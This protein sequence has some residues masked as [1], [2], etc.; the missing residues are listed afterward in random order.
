MSEVV[1]N[2]AGSNVGSALQAL[3][4]CDELVPGSDVSYELCKLIYL[5]HP[6]GAKIAEGPIAI[7]QSQRREIL[8]QDSGIQE[9]LVERFNKVWDE[10]HVDS[11]IFNAYR[12][13]RIYGV[14]T[15]V[16]GAVGVPTDQV[17]DL[18]KLKGLE[19]YFNVLDPLN[20]AGSMVFNQD[21]NSPDFQ[22]VESVTVQGSAYHRSRCQV[23][24]NEA[25]IYIHYESSGFGYTG[26]S[27]YQRA[28]FP[29]KTFVQ[30][31]ITDD[32]ITRKAGVLIAKL[33]AP[34][35]IIDALMAKVAGVK[36]DLLKSA[37]TNQVLGIELTESIETLNLQNADTAST[38]ARKN[39][40][41]NVA[42][43][44][45]MPSVLLNSETFAQGFGE[46][47][48]DAKH[49]AGYIERF[50]TEMR[51][52]YAFFDRLVQHL[53][54]SEEFYETIQAEFDEA[55]GQVPYKKAFYQWQNSFKPVWPSLLTEPDSEKVGV[56]KTKM[57]SVIS[58]LETFLPNLDPGN[59]VTTLMW[60]ADAISASEMLFEKALNLDVDSLTEFVEE[61]AKQAEAT[62]DGPEETAGDVPQ[63]PEPKVAAAQQTP[64]EPRP[65]RLQAA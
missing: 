21:P 51:P 2:L 12:Q 5:Y 31:M 46:G 10:L 15:L 42:T 36:R 33:K 59:K 45:P 60:A 20:T 32:M 53:A 58:V 18:T 13:A 19:L 50:R 11:H 62:P 48:E 1:L 35:S 41:E 63:R 27:V 34:G 57:E 40:L 56:D 37:V 7:A 16:Y 14:A 44:V 26:R 8:I 9:R 22:R 30:S 43:A 54:F 64:P 24:M 47:T 17:I 55:Y 61:Q 49:V 23:V 65:K 25:P 28:L 4:M 39:A 29:L 6:L 3:L 38:A 52:I